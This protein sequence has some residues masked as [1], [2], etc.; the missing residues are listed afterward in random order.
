[1]CYD[2]QDECVGVVFKMKYGDYKKKCTSLLP[3]MLIR[4]NRWAEVLKKFVMKDKNMYCVVTNELNV[5]LVTLV[6]SFV[7]LVKFNELKSMIGYVH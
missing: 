7:K 6:S 1:M 2:I 4:L 3:F 5:L